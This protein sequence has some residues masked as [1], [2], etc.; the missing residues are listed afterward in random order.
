MPCWCSSAAEPGLEWDAPPPLGAKGF[1]GLSALG[2]SPTDE[3]VRPPAW[4]DKDSQPQCQLWHHHGRGGA[5]WKEP[6]SGADGSPSLP[7]EGPMAVLLEWV[8]SVLVVE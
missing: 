1:G 2:D 7:Q 8:E 6:G 5:G 3:V 4:L